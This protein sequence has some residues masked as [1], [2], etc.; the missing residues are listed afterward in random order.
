[1]LTFGYTDK[2]TPNDEYSDMGFKRGLLLKE[3]VI[4]NDGRKVQATAF[5]YRTDEDNYLKQYSLTTNLRQERLSHG[6]VLTH[7]PRWCL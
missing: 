7:L 3:E 5:K 6:A 1:M 4:N 2:M